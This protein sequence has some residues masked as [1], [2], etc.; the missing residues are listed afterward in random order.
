MVDRRRT[1]YCMMSLNMAGS[2]DQSQ[3]TKKKSKKEVEE[4]GGEINE[5]IHQ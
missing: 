1:Q 5:H 2:N 3:E 4:G